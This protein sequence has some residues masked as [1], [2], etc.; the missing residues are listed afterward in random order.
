MRNMSFNEKLQKLRKMNGLSQEALAEL[1]DV[2][3]QSVS[4]WESGTTYPEMDKLLSMCKIFKCS[5]DDLTN[6][7]I[8]DIKQEKKKNSLYTLIDSILYFINQI[9]QTL[10]VMNRKEILKCIITMTMIALILLILQLPFI[11]IQNFFFET[12]EMI[13][14]ETIKNFGYHIVELL[15]HI[16]YYSLFLI[17]FIYIFQ[18][19]YLNNDTY[20]TR[21]TTKKIEP[22]EIQTQEKEP[23]TK[24]KEIEKASANIFQVLSSLIIIVGKIIVCF[25][26]LPILGLL[27]LLCAALFISLYLLLK[28]VLFIS[29]LIGIPFAI[30]LLLVILEIFFCF[31]LNRK[32]NERRI[33]IMFL[34]S[35]IGL[36]SSFG[37]LLLDINSFTYVDTTPK[38]A[39]T[40]TLTKNYEMNEQLY[41]LFSD[42]SEYQTD[43]TLGNT[44]K[45][46]ATY[47][48]DYTEITLPP[49]MHS[50]IPYREKPYAFINQH[51]LP[52]LIEDLSNRTIHN[53]AALNDVNIKIYATEQN[54]QTL[55]SNYEQEIKRQEEERIKM[56]ENDFNQE[57]YQ[58]TIDIL[59]QEKEELKQ[60]NEELRISLDDYKNKIE[61]YKNQLKSLIEE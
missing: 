46:E 41:F 54:I 12:L 28:G 40:D 61:E 51:L 1:L 38:E 52:I 10:K 32:N 18:I 24:H 43:N 42:I 31:L 3:R 23:E 16:A 50:S 30:L 55:K 29:I 59:E 8:K 22:T 53:Y 2:T 27:F 14:N 21:I 20:K 47:Y 56:E 37:I 5:L 49:E 48:K 7:E 36:G 15:I 11:T 45:I 13:N 25:F 44:I 35:I 26:T 17:I 19:L 39:T 60:K 57:S 4:K 9:Y 6:D 33:G 34:I 58:N